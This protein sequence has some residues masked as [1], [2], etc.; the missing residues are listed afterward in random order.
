MTVPTVI[1]TR[2]VPVTVAGWVKVSRTSIASPAMKAPPAPRPVAGTSI[3]KTHGAPASPSTT[4]FP[5][6]TVCAVRSRF[7][8]RPP[9][10]IVP[11]FNSSAD[12]PMLRPF[13]SSSATCT[14]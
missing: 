12:A 8:P 14:V 9:A 2:G 10:V 4:W 7:T 1:A 13:A 5:S 6:V 11:P 3:P